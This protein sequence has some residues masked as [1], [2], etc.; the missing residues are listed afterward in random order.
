MNSFMLY[1]YQY[2]T[3]IGIISLI[4]KMIDGEIRY[5]VIFDDDDFGSYHN[6]QAAAEDVAGG[7]TFA[8]G[9]LTDFGDLGVPEDLGEWEKYQYNE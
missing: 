5:S 7:H 9:D 3:R 4:P 8:P 2:K 1:Y 6:P